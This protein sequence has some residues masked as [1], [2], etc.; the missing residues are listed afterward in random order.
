MQKAVVIGLG[1]FGST[2]AVELVRRGVEVLAIDRSLRHVE[3]VADAVSVAVSFDATDRTNLEAYA[4]GAMDAAIVAIG[5]NFEAS[6][7]VTM[8]CKALGV[9]LVCAKALNPMQGD[10][11]TRVGADRVVRPEEDMGLRLAEHLTGERLVD[12]VSLPSDFVLRRF[13]VPPAWDGSSLAELRLLGDSRLCLVQIVRRADAD[14]VRR[15]E[16]L[17]HGETVLHVGDDVDAIGPVD[18]LDGITRRTKKP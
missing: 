3:E 15:K 2:I 8:H 17:P 16:P 12:F 11:L 6:V 14:G 13:P 10:V 7:L 5:T 4:L 9:P 18:V 1:R